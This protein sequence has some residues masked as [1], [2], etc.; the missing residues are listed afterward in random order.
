MG[1]KVAVDHLADNWLFN[2]S[3]SLPKHPSA[4]KHTRKALA[5]FLGGGF[6]TCHG[7]FKVPEVRRGHQI[8]SSLLCWMKHSCGAGASPIILLLRTVSCLVLRLEAPPGA[9]APVQLPPAGNKLQ[10]HQPQLLVNFNQEQFWWFLHV[11]RRAGKKNPRRSINRVALWGTLAR[12]VRLDIRTV[13][14][15]VQLICER[16]TGVVSV[17]ENFLFFFFSQYRINCIH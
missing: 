7:Y 8:S 6:S 10:H 2:T 3:K 5:V 14:Y 15:L 17:F 11:L 12:T 9:A 16:K 1:W 13:I 4:K